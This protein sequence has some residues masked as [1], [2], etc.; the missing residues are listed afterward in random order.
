M[1]LSKTIVSNCFNISVPGGSDTSWGYQ[2]ERKRGRMVGRG[3]ETE[4][5]QEMCYCTV[6][7]ECP[8]KVHMVKAGSPFHGTIRW[9]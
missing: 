7:H 5:D 6:D 8:S 2:E 3:R 9:W 1:H 4:K